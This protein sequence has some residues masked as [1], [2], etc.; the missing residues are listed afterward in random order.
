MRPY[1]FKHRELRVE[2][3]P[4]VAERNTAGIILLRV[5]T[6]TSG[7]GNKDGPPHHGAEDEITILVLLQCFV[8]AIE[9]P[10]KATTPD[11]RTRRRVSTDKPE[12]HDSCWFQWHITLNIVHKLAHA[13][14]HFKTE[15]PEYD[16]RIRFLGGIARFLQKATF[17]IVIRVKKHHVFRFDESESGISAGWRAT[18]FWQYEDLDALSGI[19]RYTLKFFVL[20]IQH[21]YY[22]LCGYF[23]KAAV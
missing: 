11:N 18:S 15:R 8:P 21:H 3:S 17:N 9:L 22:V 16:I 23:S 14:R 5:D 2:G 19:L 7:A 20:A 10:D 4:V 1:I 6:Q 12:L 13:I